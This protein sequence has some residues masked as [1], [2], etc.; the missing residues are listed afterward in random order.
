MSR[1]DSSLQANSTVAEA[2]NSVNKLHYAVSS[3]LSHPTEQM[4]EQ[5]ENSLKHT[6]KA[7]Q[8]ADMAVGR[9]GVE[10]AEE[11]LTEEKHR[12]ASL[13]NRARHSE[14]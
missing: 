6:E 14:Q 10:L 5:A 9:S 11:L 8:Q 7:V 1:Y 4:I 12:L 2:L 13:S 3:A